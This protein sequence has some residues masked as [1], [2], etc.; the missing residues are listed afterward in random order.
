MK[1]LARYRTPLVLAALCAG[2]AGF[3]AWDRTR[4]T[5]DE[6]QAR[7]RM[8]FRAFHRERVDRI[9]V[10]HRSGRPIVTLVR[11]NVFSRIPPS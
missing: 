4:A 1:P 9:V 7:Q 11:R 2:F 5:T 10:Q 8:V 3:I 6:L